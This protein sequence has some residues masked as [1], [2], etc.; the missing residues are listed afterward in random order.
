MTTANAMMDLKGYREF[1]KK[2]DQDIH[3]KLAF[4]SYMNGLL[5]GLYWSNF[6]AT[7]LG[8]ALFCPKDNEHI[9]IDEMITLMDME[10]RKD[11]QLRDE[12]MPV[13]VVALS[14]LK[15]GFPCPWDM[16]WRKKK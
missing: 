9:T 16:R 2:A 4:D 10:F 3:Y 15:D 13:G 7:N 6:A 14:A 1:R 12:R 5:D 11:A 8:K